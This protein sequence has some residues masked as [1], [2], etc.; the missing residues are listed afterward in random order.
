[1]SIV[2]ITIAISAVGATIVAAGAQLVVKLTL[3]PSTTTVATD[4]T[5]IA[6]HIATIPHCIAGHS[7]L[8][9]VNFTAMPSWQL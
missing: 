6:P 8:L 3:L 9:L 7:R 2:V 5:I 1:M 4:D